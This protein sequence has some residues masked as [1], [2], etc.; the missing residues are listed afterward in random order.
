[1]LFGNLCQVTPEDVLYTCLPLYHTSG[2]GIG[3]SSAMVNGASIVIAK[4]FSNAQFWPEISRHGCTV[5]QYIGELCRYIINY[6]ESHPEVKA[7]PHRVRWAV[8]NGLR[9][10][11]WDAFQDGFNIQNVC[12]FYGATESNGILINI[13]AKDDLRARGSVGRVGYIWKKIQKYKIAKFNLETEELIRN[14][15]GLCIECKP[16][17]VG[18]LLFPI[19]ENRPHTRFLGYTDE[20]ATKKKVAT[21]VFVKGDKFFRTG[22]LLSVDIDGYFY[23]ADR[24]GDTFRWKGENVS[25]TEVAEALTTYVGIDD[26]NVYGVKVPGVEDGRGCMVAITLAPEAIITDEW[27]DGFTAHVQDALPPYA[28]PLFIRVLEQAQ[29]TSTFKQQ[30]GTLRDEGC[31]P[32]KITDALYWLRPEDRKYR[33]YTTEEFRTLQHGRAKL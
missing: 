9:P 8:G 30:K 21:D 19:M 20:K 22:D 4:R 11:I 6:A 33:K 1:M 27:L 25:T 17:E 31:D 5:I 24:I 23:F 18:E 28:Q 16:D 2:G 15:D 10:E 12:E 3:V 7:I 13:C 29:M 14:T 26:A 32:S